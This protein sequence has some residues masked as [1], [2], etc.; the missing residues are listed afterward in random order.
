MEAPEADPS[1]NSHKIDEAPAEA[2]GN[3]TRHLV[4]ETSCFA[5]KIIPIVRVHSSDLIKL[6][7]I[8]V[9]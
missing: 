7:S 8:Y 4:M 9:P 6:L 2:A 3:S 1:P 5:F